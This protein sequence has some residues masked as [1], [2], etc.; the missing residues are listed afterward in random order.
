MDKDKKKK[1]CYVSGIAVIS[2]LFMSYLA[3]SLFFMNHYYPG[4]MIGEFS[5][6]GLTAEGAKA[7]IEERAGN[8]QLVIIGR[9]ETEATLTA[10][11][12]QLQ[13]QLDDTLKDIVN[14]QNGFAWLSGGGQYD[15]PVTVS[16]DEG[17]LNERLSDM[18]IFQRSHMRKPSNAYIGEYD[19]ETGSYPLVAEDRGTMINRQKAQ[20]AIVQAIENMEETILLDEAGC[21]TEPEISQDNEALVRFCSRLN[22][23]VSSRIVYDWHGMEE[24]VDGNLIHD[25]LDIDR[26]KQIVSI[27]AEGVREYI[28][29]LSKKHDTFGK[30]REFRTSEGKLITIKT[31]SYGW[32]VDRNKETERLLKLIRAGSQVN[33]EPEYLYTAAAKGENDIG[34]S[35]VEINLSAQH[36]YLY[37]KGELI[38]E[39]DFV[40]GSV[41]RG[42]AT[43]DGVYSLTYKTR[44]ATLRGQ[45]Y[46][47]PVDFWMPFNGNIG[48]HDASWRRQFGGTIY[49]R[50]GSH[51]CVNLPREEAEKIYEYVDKGFP[52][53]CYKEES[54]GNS[55]KKNNQGNTNTQTDPAQTPGA[56]DDPNVLPG[57]V[58][59]VDPN[60][61]IGVVPGVGTEPGPG[62]VP[63]TGEVPVPGT[64][65]GEIPGNGAGDPATGQPDGG[66]V[67]VPVVPPDQ[68]VTGQ[69]G[70]EGMTG[71]DPGVVPAPAVT[72]EPI[73]AP[74]PGAQ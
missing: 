25:W 5:C 24:V 64:V 15:L 16:Y 27:N 9:E 14:R 23:F 42:F 49:L 66:N 48:M 6:G 63:G 7:L 19:E 54:S 61:G 59:P 12:I 60:T 10:S 32:R 2:L 31:G 65:P 22:R 62:G 47:S 38:T 72:P 37:V 69:P 52:V 20:T 50:N 13:F 40:S 58:V 53:V 33:R 74:V 35:Y 29:S 1:I 45:G 56:V 36:L 68:G 43:P 55:I 3:V 44:N 21:Y 30:A 70:A 8:Y 18:L 51:G 41:A 28:N 71:A 39:S 73:P 57:V 17:L 67:P 26:E 34:D 11:E 46:A 4:T